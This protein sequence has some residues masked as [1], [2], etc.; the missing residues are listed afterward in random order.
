[1]IG[2]DTNVLV[3]Y[4]TQ[5]DP[6]QSPIATRFL[7]SEL[8]VQN[9]GFVA[10][11]VLC[12]FAWVLERA[13]KLGRVELALVLGQVL[14]IE[15]LEHEHWLDATEAVREFQSGRLNFSD[16]FI[17]RMA[18]KSGCSELVTFDAAL[19]RRGGVRLLA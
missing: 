17:A 9:K 10:A 1:V 7:E 18:E 11:I 16:C 19:A 13:F 8:S 2:V 4:V 6:V 15:V 14:S 3:R 5:D 12:E